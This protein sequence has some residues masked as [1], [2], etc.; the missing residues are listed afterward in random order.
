[1]GSKVSGETSSASGATAAG[2]GSRSP[3]RKPRA[4]SGLGKPWLLGTRGFSPKRDRPAARK[5]LPKF[6]DFVF[7]TGVIA[8][9]I[10]TGNGP[11][12]HCQKIR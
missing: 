4:M 12:C 2:L 9:E 5:G 8:R 7:I 1:M 10:M 11:A 6:L 3:G